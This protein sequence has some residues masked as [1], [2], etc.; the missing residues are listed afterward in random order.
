MP[1][2][3][4]FEGEGRPILRRE[5]ATGQNFA[6]KPFHIPG[7]LQAK[8]VVI[9]DAAAD[10]ALLLEKFTARVLHAVSAEKRHFRHPLK[11]CDE[12]TQMLLI[13][14]DYV[15]KLV[16]LPV[17]ED[18]FPRPHRIS[19]EDQPQAFARIGDRAYRMPWELKHLKAYSAAQVDDV[20]LFHG[21]QRIRSHGI[22]LHGV[23]MAQAEALDL[24][25]QRLH[26]AFMQVYGA[27]PPAFA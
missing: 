26:V 15:V 14:G 12:V 25:R 5:A 27:K 22:G 19:R 11:P 13:P 9:G 20:A 21:A 7:D 18:D 4:I 8:G 16:A 17:Q 10:D 23:G 6:A 1:P 24:P 2:A 3:A